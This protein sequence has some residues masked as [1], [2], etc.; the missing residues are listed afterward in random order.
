MVQKDK[1]QKIIK[2]VSFSLQENKIYDTYSRRE[3]DRLPIES[4]VYLHAYNRLSWFDINEIY[5]ELNQ[6]KLKEMQVHEMSKS[7]TRIHK[8][9]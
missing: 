6:Y 7:N 5:F 2:S 9:T 8:S 4:V 3:Y 1:Q